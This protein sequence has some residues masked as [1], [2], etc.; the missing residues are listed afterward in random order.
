MHCLWRTTAGH[1]I[2][3]KLYVYNRNPYVQLILVVR[4]AVG[5]HM[6]IPQVIT[7][8]KYFLFTLQLGHFHHYE[9]VL[10]TATQPHHKHQAVHV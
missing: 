5:P 10:Y 2:S 6:E 3:Y 7:K 9:W 1:R 4:A 8:L